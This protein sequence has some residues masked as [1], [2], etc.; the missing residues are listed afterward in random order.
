VLSPDNRRVREMLSDAMSAPA[1]V[2]MLLREIGADPKALAPAVAFVATIIKARHP[3][4][5]ACARACVRASCAHACVCAC[6]RVRAAAVAALCGVS[7]SQSGTAADG[8]PVGR[9]TPRTWAPL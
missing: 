7:R 5:R 3:R 9:P 8:L 1:G 2:P 4:L 6:V